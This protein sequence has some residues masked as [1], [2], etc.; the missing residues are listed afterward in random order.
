MCVSAYISF[1]CRGF[2]TKCFWESCVLVFVVLWIG[3][4]S[5]R[6]QSTDFQLAL[7]RYVEQADKSID[8]SYYLETLEALRLSPINLNQPEQWQPLLELQLVDALQLSALQTYI[9][10][11]GYLLSVNELLYIDGF[12]LAEV[13][14]LQYVCVAKQIGAVRRQT[15]NGLEQ[16]LLWRYQRVFRQEDAY[17]PVSDSAWI[18]RPNAYYLGSPDKLY[19]RYKLAVRHKWK[20][21]IV[22]EK[23]AGEPFFKLA[24]LGID[25]LIKRPYTHGFDFYSAFV[26]AE[27]V[28]FLNTIVIGDY[29]LRLGQGLN[30]WTTPSFG[31]GIVVESAQ[32]Y[33]AGIKGNTSANEAAFL[34]GIATDMSLVKPLSLLLFTAHSPRDALVKEADSGTYISSIS[35][36]GYHRTPSEL[37][38]KHALQIDLL[39][40]ALQFTS[41]QWR[42]SIMNT[43]T[44][45]SQLLQPQNAVMYRRFVGNKMQISG[46]DYAFSL[47]NMYFFGECSYHHQQ[48]T[49]AFLMGLS[50]NLSQL[51]KYTM[52]Y[53]YYPAAYDNIWA[54]AFGEHSRNSNER[55]LYVGLSLPI[56]S[57]CKLKAY[58]DMYKHP[59]IKLLAS[60]PSYGYDHGLICNY[61]A[62]QEV[63]MYAHLRYCYKGHNALVSDFFKQPEYYSVYAF[64]YHIA[65]ALSAQLSMRSQVDYRWVRDAHISQG[66]YLAQDIGYADK[67][68][69]WAVRLRMAVF[70]TD[71]Y[72]ARIYAYEHN[73][74]YA[75]NVPAFYHKG[76]RSYIVVRYKC[77][78]QLSFWC[79]LAAT[80]YMPMAKGAQSVSAQLRNGV[81]LSLQLQWKPNVYKNRK[82]PDGQ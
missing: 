68:D 80:A 39:G 74:L 42:M 29:H 31:K 54:N 28:G 63:L 38:K 51:L 18:K 35:Q 17:H 66:L 33:A 11:N 14:L 13:K 27:G 37:N 19:M 64:R 15:K 41:A 56:T 47:P 76:L 3:H 43:Y 34:R 52:L 5:L 55:G 72:S 32:K 10:N 16:Q 67:T 58:A 6:A 49:M 78:R 81:E 36:D 70:S 61:K 50:G 8:Y 1:K 60:A 7:E 59:W 4:Q 2:Y 23:D 21:A 9:Q 73:V 30:M 65:Y 75:F 48:N 12:T 82:L 69:R 71:D 77:S 57:K 25:T 20:A 53:R 44:H 45:F 24:R 40:A 26:G 79:K 62:S 46:A 22:A